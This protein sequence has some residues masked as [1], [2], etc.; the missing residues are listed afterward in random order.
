MPQ[1]EKGPKI[2]VGDHIAFAG[3][4]ING[5]QDEENFVA[6]QPVLEVAIKWKE[7]GVIFI[8]V[9]RALLKIERKSVKRFC[10]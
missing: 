10:S 5:K 1:M 9:W 7:R 4:A 2:I 8:R 3:L 6:E